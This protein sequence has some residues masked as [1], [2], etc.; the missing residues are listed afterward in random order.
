MIGFS[1]LSG[2]G[3]IGSYT[4]ELSMQ[5]KWEKKKKGGNA[6]EKE[7]KT[8]A[9]RAMAAKKA[10][11]RQVLEDFREK[12]EN[13]DTLLE[14]IHNK[15]TYGEP[16]TP[17][18]MEYLKAKEPRTYETVKEEKEDAESL[19]KRLERAK[20]KEEAQKIM[21]DHA[22]KSLAAVQLV[23]GNPHIKEAD[24][25]A[26][27]AAEVRKLKKAD[28]VFEKFRE[29]GTYDQLPTETEKKMAEED[30]RDAEEKELREAAKAPETQEKEMTEGTMPEQEIKPS[31]ADS[32]FEQKNT[33]GRDLD[34]KKSAADERIMKNEHRKEL[35]ASE[36]RNTEHAQKVRRAKLK[37][38]FEVYAENSPESGM[39][40]D[41]DDIQSV[42]TKI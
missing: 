27:M 1:S 16:L 42:N 35:H 7:Y 38:H 25:T 4:K 26:I 8:E 31:R 39:Y 2:M 28:A 11:D 14:K 22:N 32:L 36:A 21:Q 19:K 29:S 30:I 37:K 13:A 15:L 6:L 20:T 17:K 9:G 41:A 34:R 3:R 24:K 12:Q 40:L 10:A 33:S 23:N 18:E 5:Q